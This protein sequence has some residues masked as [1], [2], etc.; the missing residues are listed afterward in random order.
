[1][2]AARVGTQLSV[3]GCPEPKRSE[4]DLSRAVRECLAAH[5]I[6][7]ER[8]QSGQLMVRDARRGGTYWV[9]CAS[10]GTPDLW[11]ELGWIECKVR[12]GKVS[13]VQRLWHERAA[14]H[15]VRVH[16]VRSVAD[17]VALIASE[18]VSLR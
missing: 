5:R 6:L 9:H 4:T 10:P 14:R 16:I 18:R 17:V 1:M 8:V 11:T 2:M 12:N 3:P 15:G 7:H 13:D